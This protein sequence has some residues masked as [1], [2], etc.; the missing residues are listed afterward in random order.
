MKAL[1]MIAAALITTAVWPSGNEAGRVRMPV[2]SSSVVEMRGKI[3]STSLDPG[4]CPPAMK[5]Q[6][7][8]SAAVTVLLRCVRCMREQNFSPK[9]GEV[10]EVKGYSVTKEKAKGEILA[11]SVR[12]P[13][14]DQTLL[15]RDGAGCP[16]CGLGCGHHGSRHASSDTCCG[17]CD[18]R[19]CRR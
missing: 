3:L 10:A 15:L 5:V 14:S 2:A 13:E 17:S 4:Q 16:E 9:V 19:Q 18:H 6:P 11:V 7:E 8:G 12:L 1:M